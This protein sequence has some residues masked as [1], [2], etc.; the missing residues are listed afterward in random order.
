MIEWHWVG[1][2]NG[3]LQMNVYKRLNWRRGQGG[4]GEWR[5]RGCL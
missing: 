3:R 4:G 2:M 5:R 1:G